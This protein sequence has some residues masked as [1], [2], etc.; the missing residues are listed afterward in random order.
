MD[1]TTPLTG[2]RY[3]YKN[4]TRLSPSSPTGLSFTPMNVSDSE[5]PG[6]FH[7]HG[8]AG[9]NLFENEKLGPICRI[10]A[11][12]TAA[13]LYFNKIKGDADVDSMAVLGRVHP[14]S[15]YYI[16]TVLFSFFISIFV[17]GHFVN[18]ALLMLLCMISSNK[19]I[20]TNMNVCQ[21]VSRATFDL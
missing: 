13:V 14:Y 20:F 3:F 4:D 18:L 2:E 8:T 7:L 19:G 17:S 10:V 9:D 12:L 11:K 5:I 16:R 21:K 1:Q 15:T 6:T